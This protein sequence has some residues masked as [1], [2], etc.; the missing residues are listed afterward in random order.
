MLGKNNNQQQDRARAMVERAQ[1]AYHNT[2]KI[3]RFI[4]IILL[5]SMIPLL[6]LL[7]QFFLYLGLVNYFLKPEENEPR[8]SAW[9]KNIIRVILK[10]V[11]VV[12]II[13][14]C[15]LLALPALFLWLLTGHSL[16]RCGS[17]LT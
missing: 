17:F 3:R 8:L 6:F 5:V 16:E 14:S 2:D 9:P 15:I 12:C 4:N 11:L 1:N 7:I 13:A 10:A